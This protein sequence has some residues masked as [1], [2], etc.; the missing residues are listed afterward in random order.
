MRRQINL[1]GWCLVMGT[2]VVPSL[3]GQT[4]ARTT[5]N[6]SVSYISGGSIYIDAG[7][8][9]GYEVGDTVTVS[10]KRD[11]VCTAVI[12]AVSSSS[13]SAKVVFERLQPAIGDHASARKVVISQSSQS[14]PRLPEPTLPKATS[15]DNIVSGYVALSYAATAWEGQSFDVSQPGAVI[16]F[17]IS[18]LAGTGMSFSMYGRTSYDF[19]GQGSRFSPQSGMDTRLYE[20]ALTLENPTSWFGFS[21]GRVS[22][23]YVTGMGLFDGAQFYV[24]M[25][26]FRLGAFGG[27][28]SENLRYSFGTK[29]QKIGAFVSYGW[30][31]GVFNSSEITLAYGKAMVGGR[32]D[33]DYLY[34]QSRVRLS[35]KLF[36]YQSAEIDMH[37]M[38]EG[39]PASKLGFTNTYVSVTYYPLQWLNVSAGYDAT[40]AIYLFESM[41]TISDT[42]VDQSLRQ[43]LRGSLS[44]RLPLNVVVNAVGTFRPASGVTPEAHTLGGGAR[45]S[46]IRN[47]G[48]S[49]GGQYT[50][51]ASLYTDG[52]DLTADISWWMT[53]Q[54]SASLRLDRYQYTA[55]GDVESFRTVT[56]SVSVSYRFSRSLYAMVFVD[57][58]WDSLQDLRRL[59]LECGFHF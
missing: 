52:V 22:S 32:L 10:R 18:K 50:R 42:L 46:D 5:V 7:R 38:E 36:F 29:K 25:G 58:V 40:R 11:T 21:I 45:I 27:W 59:Y 13:S 43:G 34:L 33:R 57:Q 16:K 39:T 23:R 30:G 20:A 54:L 28:Q 2:F 47:T 12:V 19:A 15:G 51:I 31:P 6:A 37:S 44:V 53:D 3:W 8:D 17:T 55:L 49:V 14:T 26:G 35:S 56:G 4:G 9:A 24:R 41:K 48:I 1:L